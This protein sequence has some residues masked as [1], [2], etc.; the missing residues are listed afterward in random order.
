MVKHKLLKLIGKKRR[1]SDIDKNNSINTKYSNKCKFLVQYILNL[2]ISKTKAITIITKSEN[3][4]MKPWARLGRTC[5]LFSPAV[6][7][8]RE[9]SLSRYN[10]ERILEEGLTNALPSK[11]NSTSSL[12]SSQ[13]AKRL[14]MFKTSKTSRKLFKKMQKQAMKNTQTVLRALSGACCFKRKWALR[15]SLKNISI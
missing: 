15:A 9:N 3:F 10:A 14:L 4:K 11:T 12:G 6:S 8:D 13:P 7:K 5:K 2:F 1:F